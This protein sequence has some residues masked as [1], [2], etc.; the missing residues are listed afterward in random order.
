MRCG[1][2]GGL[3]YGGGG[4]VISSSTTHSHGLLLY[5]YCA[6]AGGD[7]IRGHGVRMMKLLLLLELLLL[8]LLLLLLLLSLLSRHE[9]VPRLLRRRRH[10]HGNRR[11]HGTHGSIPRQGSIHGIQGVHRIARGIRRDPLHL[12]HINARIRRRRVR[13]RNARLAHGEGVVL[14]GRRGASIRGAAIGRGGSATVQL[15]IRHGHRRNGRGFRS[16]SGAAIVVQIHLAAQ[17]MRS[18]HPDGSGASSDAE[19]H[20]AAGG[21]AGSHGIVI[22]REEFIGET[23]IGYSWCHCC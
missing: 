2:T 22:D 8:K 17:D 21:D 1:G 10:R 13:V 9:L 6:A 5:S 7:A 11:P 15:G 19:A 23:I 4:V 3:G 14:N 18:R 12:D 20:A 16:R